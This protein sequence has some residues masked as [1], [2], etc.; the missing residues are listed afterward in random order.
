VGRK[1]ELHEARQQHVSDGYRQAKHDGP[2]EQR[3]NRGRGAQRYPRREQDQSARQHAPRAEPAG[4]SGSEQRE[5]GEA[6]QG[7]GGQQPRRPAR[8]AGV[9]PDL[10]G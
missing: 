3:R 10:P 1:I 9:G 4:Q 7:Q 2:G 5:G 6:D 8:D